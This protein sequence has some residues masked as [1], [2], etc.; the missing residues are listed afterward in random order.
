MVA[1]DEHGSVREGSDLAVAEGGPLARRKPI[2]PS[3]GLEPPIAG[4]AAEPDDD[5]D[6]GEEAQLAR[7]PGTA[8]VKLLCGGPIAWRCAARG[9]GDV[10]IAEMEAIVPAERLGLVGEA[11]PVERLV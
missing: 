10:A 4:D 11:E 1:G 5:L 7:E 8:M 9:R 3:R 2:P 6:L